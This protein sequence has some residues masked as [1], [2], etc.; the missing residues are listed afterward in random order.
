MVRRLWSPPS[1]PRLVPLT[2]DRPEHVAAHDIGAARTHEPIGGG[3]V[4]PGRARVADV[5]AVQL[6]SAL[7]QWILQALF[8][9]GN[10]AV[11]R[12]RHV[13]GGVRH[14]HLPEAV[15]VCKW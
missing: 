14:R 7:A 11:E 1:V 13:A 3:L 15:A 9:A 10:E 12:N 6:E 8:G 5:P 2:A 4:V